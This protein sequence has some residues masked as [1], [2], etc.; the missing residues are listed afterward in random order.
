MKLLTNSPA[1]SHRELALRQFSGA[2]L[3]LTTRKK[4]LPCRTAKHR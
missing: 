3:R 2:H 4:V 1:G